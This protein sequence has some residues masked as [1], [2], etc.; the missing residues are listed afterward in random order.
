MHALD[1]SGWGFASKCFEAMAWAT[2]AN[3][4]AL[5]VRTSTEFTWPIKVGRTDRAEARIVSRDGLLVETEASI[6]H[7]RARPRATARATFQAMDAG[8]AADAVGT[9][10]RGNATGYVEG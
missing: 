3:A 5:T 10:V 2:I 4:F 8:Q 6:L 1:N 7:E 9:G